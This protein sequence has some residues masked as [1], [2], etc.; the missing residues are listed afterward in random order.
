MSGPIPKHPVWPSGRHGLPVAKR[1][2]KLLLYA[3]TYFG[4][5]EELETDMRFPGGTD[6]SI[7]MDKIMG[8][9]GLCKIADESPHFTSLSGRGTDKMKNRSTCA[10]DKD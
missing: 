6:Y 5:M 7:F 1:N 3:D 10:I 9:V 2:Q 8:M 4:C